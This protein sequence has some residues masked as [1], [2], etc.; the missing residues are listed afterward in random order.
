MN[1]PRVPLHAINKTN[2]IINNAATHPPP[3]SEPQPFTKPVPASTLLAQPQ[4][5]KAA[6][7]PKRMIADDLLPSFKQA[8][9]GS[10][11]TKA[12]LVEVLKKQYVKLSTLCYAA[13]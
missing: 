12:G 10:N 5:S 13:M 8:V 6:T 3:I 7:K 2:V 4:Q 9:Q 1:P 11:L